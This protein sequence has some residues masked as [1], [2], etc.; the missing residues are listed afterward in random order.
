LPDRCK[1]SVVRVAWGPA[2][3]SRSS[4]AAI[5][6]EVWEVPVVSF[7]SF[8][9]GVPA[10]LAIGTVELEDG[11]R[12]KSFLCEAHATKGARDITEFGGWRKYL[13]RQHAA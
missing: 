10:P 5:E 11:L 6:V 7:G 9:G 4:G 12:V 2:G 13:A 3:A 1:L 8:V